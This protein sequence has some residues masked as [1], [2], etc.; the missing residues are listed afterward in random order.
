M[1]DITSMNVSDIIKDSNLIYEGKAKRIYKTNHENVILSHFKDDLTA[2]NAQK[3]GSE[4]RK[5]ELNC[6]ISSQI[7]AI[8]EQKGIKTHFLGIL[9]SVNMVCKRVNIIPIEVVV[10]NIATGSLTKRLGIKEGI[11]IKDSPLG[12]PLVEFYY[13]D[14]ALEDPIIND[15]HC[16]LM[17][18]ANPSE[19]AQLKSLALSVNEVLQ[20]YFDKAN[21]NLI[22]F[23]LEFGRDFS[24]EVLLADEI[25]PDSCRLWD[26]ESNKKMDKDIEETEKAFLE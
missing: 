7:F 23:K 12:S 9:D 8:L 3:K 5:G 13:K 15:S 6:K 20:S 22:D 11:V 25:S 19:I 21:L 24:G 1:I 16:L 10:R 14:D 4:E 17:N 26:K 2:F 18:L